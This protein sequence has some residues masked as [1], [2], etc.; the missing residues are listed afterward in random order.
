[1]LKLTFFQPEDIDV[2][3]N[4]A[5][6]PGMDPDYMRDWA[7][8]NATAGPAFTGW[9]QGEIVGAA[10]IRRRRNGAGEPWFIM[11]QDK[12]QNIK[13]TFR[14]VRTMLEILIANHNFAYLMAP[15]EI[16]FDASQ[17]FLEHLGFKKKRI[18]HNKK[19]Y[20]YRKECA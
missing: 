4:N 8:F 15:S 12:T 9:M 6:E 18:M 16:G 20:Y 5:I 19:H 14:T 7:E 11:R 10:G 2:F 17:R 13:S 1:V 3:I